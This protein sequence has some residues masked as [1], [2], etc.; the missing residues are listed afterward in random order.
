VERLAAE[1]RLT[2]IPDVGATIAAKIDEL[3]SSGRLAAL[4]KLTARYPAGLVE[5]MRLPGIGAKT[6]RRLFETLGVRT[7]DDLRAACERGDV[8]AVSGLGEKTQE[9]ILEAI[10][11]GVAPR[12]QVILVDRAWQRATFFLEALRQHPACAAVSAAGSLRR[13]AETVGDVDLVAATGDPAALIGYFTGLDV[14][15]EVL[16]RG[17]A[18]GSVVTNDAVQ[19][20]LR[21]AEAGVYGNLLQHLTG[22]KA[23]N[24]ALREEAV[25]RG[26]SI[27]EWGI[28]HTETGEVWRSEDEDDVYRYLGYQPI[29]PELR[30]NHG[31]LAAAR[32]GTLPVL[33]GASDLRGDLHAHTRASDGHDS[34][35]A[36]AQAAIDRGYEYLAITDH[37]AAVGMGIGL[38]PDQLRRHVEQIRTHAAGL[39][40]QGFYLLAGAEVD[41]LVDGGLA[42]PDELLQSLD[43]VVASVHQGQRLDRDRM[44][45]RLVAA[46]ANPHVDVIGHPTG[47]MFGRRDAY[48]VDLQALIRTCAEHGTFL[49]VNANPRRL[50]LSGTAVRSA[51]SAGVKIVVS[52]DA[53]RASSLELIRYG[54]TTARRGWAQA[55]DVVN[56]RT[57]LEMA[58]LRKPGRPHPGLPR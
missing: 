23:H 38:E 3:R 51:I 34:I 8:A 19:V 41:I 14:V 39:R 29:P 37:S 24:V 45:A 28:Q 33:F 47:R 35:Q 20:D 31:E 30:E 43:W 48:D 56:T 2:E 1:G 53:H 15:G 5:I 40:D 6:T 4:D 16:A 46:A 49:E 17:D 44:T 22:S 54:V 12:K 50:D 58:A 21:V 11:T 9:R 52:T 18:R 42:F 26:L 13:G 57:W 7:L 55:S 36:M 32:A 27:S 10:R 25:T